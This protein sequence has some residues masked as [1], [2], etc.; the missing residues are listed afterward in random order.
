MY[1]RFRFTLGKIN[2]CSIVYAKLNIKP[3][4]ARK[5]KYGTQ[6]NAGYQD[7]K[8]SKV[9]EFIHINLAKICVQEKVFVFLC[10]LCG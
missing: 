4:G 10:G 2:W 7:F 6:M 8:H 3:Q 1:L 9:N 5:K